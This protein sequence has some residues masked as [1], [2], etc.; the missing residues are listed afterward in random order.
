M[1]QLL[2]F[3][4]IFI[5]YINITYA[6]PI[7]LLFVSSDF[8][9]L[10]FWFLMSGIITIFFYFKNLK[11][12]YK[13]IILLLL[14]LSFFPIKYIY[15]YY[16]EQE[17]LKEYKQNILSLWLQ[18]FYYNFWNL[19]WNY[20]LY[21][22]KWDLE[23]NYNKYYLIDIRENS[24]LFNLPKN[25]KFHTIRFPN[26][27][28]NHKKILWNIK[29]PILVTCIDWERWRMVSSFLGNM[30]YNSYYLKWGLSGLNIDYWNRFNW[31]RKCNNNEYDQKI[32]IW[33]NDNDTKTLDIPYMQLTEKDI[34]KIISYFLKKWLLNK[35]KSI[36]L[37]CDKNK[38]L[39]CWVW[40]QSLWLFLQGLWF[41]KVYLWNN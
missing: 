2:L 35:E 21:I 28:K 32:F 29:K 10:F 22:E 16:K 4:V 1:K 20:D 19:V 23:N 5:F 36:S 14:V 34:E 33:I 9:I 39:N 37:I 24:E 18:D 27:L 15:I 6:L 3:F 7:W 12:V 17:Y 40:R 11:L 31:I 38:W 41:N 25:Y 26:L 8:F 13:T 30:W